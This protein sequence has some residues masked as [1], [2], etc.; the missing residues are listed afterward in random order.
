MRDINVP[1]EETRVTVEAL[2][3]AGVLSC[4]LDEGSG[5]DGLLACALG[6]MHAALPMQR[7]ASS[8]SSQQPRESTNSYEGNGGSPARTASAR[9]ADAA[10]AEL[11]TENLS[12]NERSPNG[13]RTMD[14]AAS[15]SSSTSLSVSQASQA[16]NRP[17]RG[18]AGWDV[19]HDLSREMRRDGRGELGAG[20][21]D[22]SLGAHPRDGSSP[23]SL[24]Q[25]S[26]IEAQSSEVTSVMGSVFESEPSMPTTECVSPG[27][28][29]PTPLGPLRGPVPCLLCF[30]CVPT[31]LTPRRGLADT[32][33]VAVLTSPS[34]T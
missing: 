32:A 34:R 31:L 14:M 23:T 1:N 29:P 30:P 17:G 26:L 13:Q 24:A 9:S 8:S 28:D 11:S 27:H 6:T 21:G 3:D 15:S 22:A 2:V 4:S 5:G 19:G 10:S 12:Q 16:T 7:E 20:G 33:R 18:E 25:S